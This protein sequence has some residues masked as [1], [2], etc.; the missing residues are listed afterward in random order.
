MSGAYI[1]MDPG[2]RN[3]APNLVYRGLEQ[4]PGIRNGEPG[5][6]FTLDARRVGSLTAGAPVFWRDVTVGEVLGYDIGDGTGPVLVHIFVHAPY[7]G[8]VREKSHFWNASGL[9]VQAGAQ[10]VHIEVASLQA[11]LS[12]GVAFNTPA[13]G[14][15]S[16]AAPARPSFSSTATTMR[17]RR[18]DSPRPKPS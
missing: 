10:G 13:A 3:G 16:P 1:E 18:L 8:F 4:P 9:S 15:P 2:A 12:G 7:D 14:D 6:T 5:R 17:L 11:L